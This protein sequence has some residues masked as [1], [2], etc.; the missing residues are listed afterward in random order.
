MTDDKKKV[1]FALGL[2]ALFSSSAFLAKNVIGE[3]QMP[4]NYNIVR[5]L[6]NLWTILSGYVCFRGIFDS[7]RWGIV[8][9][10]LYV[11][12]VYRIYC[13]FSADGL[14]RA[15]MMSFLPPVLY[16]LKIL[17]T[18]RNGIKKTVSGC[19]FFLAGLGG[20]LLSMFAPGTGMI[21]ERANETFQARGI[22][23]AQLFTY[24]LRDGDGFPF[25]SEGLVG[26]RPIGIGWVFLICLVIFL[27]IWFLGED[28]YKSR[29]EAVYFR[30][31]AILGL[32]FMI[33]TLQSFPWDTLAGRFSLIGLMAEN[34]SSPAF[35]LA[36]AS[37]DL[38]IV[39]CFVAR[40]FCENKKIGFRFCLFLLCVWVVTSPLFL[41]DSICANADKRCVVT[42]ENGQSQP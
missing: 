6:L 3:G 19:V 42:T 4:A 22:Y 13:L 29:S 33:V 17:M 24:F 26:A 15:L 14:S 28:R 36:F 32:I 21:S 31:I 34:L 5:I 1:L 10:T 2:I 8:G 12:S 41:S 16:G 40:H 20:A 9:C 35:F 18:D 30:G 39:S 37:A 7:K 23:L 27:L 25:T 11:F 38:A